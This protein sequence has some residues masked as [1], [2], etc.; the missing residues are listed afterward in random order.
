MDK[1]IKDL[2]ITGKTAIYAGNK[3]ASVDTVSNEF[4][5]IFSSLAETAE[6][7]NMIVLLRHGNSQRIRDSEH[8]LN[9]IR[10]ILNDRI[11][12]PGCS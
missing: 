6:R 10:S 7:D 4:R 5:K 12:N 9:E 1:L 2:R 8:I 3:V 11:M